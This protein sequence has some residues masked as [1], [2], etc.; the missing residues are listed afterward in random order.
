MA[1]RRNFLHIH[2]FSFFLKYL[3]AKR[4]LRTM[5]VCTGEHS[6]SAAVH[7]SDSYVSRE[8]LWV[9]VVRLGWSSCGQTVQR[10]QGEEDVRL[11]LEGPRPVLQQLAALQVRG[12]VLHADGLHKITE[13]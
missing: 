6:G 5:C 8:E 9:S 10:V 7:P 1:K 13:V 3:T 12:D 2:F 4:K 11:A